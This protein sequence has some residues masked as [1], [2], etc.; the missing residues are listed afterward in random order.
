MRID[1]LRKQLE[2]EKIA[3]LLVTDKINRRYLCGFTGSNGLLL[4][5]E[6]DARLFVDGRYTQ[7]AQQQTSNVEIFEIPVGGSLNETLRPFVEGL[8]LGFEAGTIGY[9]TFTGFQALMAEVG[10]RLV[11]TN[12]LVEGLRMIKTP[13][14]IRAIKQAAAIADQTLEVILPMIRSGMTELELANE[15]DYRSKKL[16]SEGP[17][18]ETI[19]ASGER[20]ALPHAHASQKKIAANELIMIDFGAIYQGYYSD[21][22]RTF[23]FGEVSEEIKAAYQK[24]LAAQKKAVEAVAFG[25]TLGDIDQTARQA[26]EQQNLAQYF[27]HNLGHGIG[28]SCH[29]YPALAPQAALPIEK[30]MTFTIEPGVY[31]AKDSFGIRIEDD[32][33][34]NDAGCAEILT[35]FNKEWMTIDCNG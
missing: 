35:K 25:K 11:A 10:G 15:I 6:K 1:Q 18:F 33:W 34:V 20:T 31:L 29:E 17:A 16:G 21:I 12:N 28:L 4:V 32:V 26:L 3:G 23:G 30:N 27:S 8:T 14:E 7:Q 13:E 2:K 9:Q 24:V 19:V 22:T 5:T